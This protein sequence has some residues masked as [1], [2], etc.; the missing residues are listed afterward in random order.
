MTL[1]IIIVIVLVLLS[2]FFSAS[3]TALVSL[4]PAKVRTL[5]ESHKPGSASLA[6]LKQQHHRTLITI[7][8]GNNFVNIAA[9]ALTT[10][11]VT[12]QYGSTAVGIAT[13]VLTLLVLI[14]GEIIP[15][16][17]ATSYSRQFSL[18]FAP[19]LYLLTIILIPI[20][21]T[22]DKFVHALLAFLGSKKQKQVTDEELI[23]MAAIGEEEG[24]ID[25][26]ERAFIENALEFNDI[27]VEEVMTP[28]VH[29]SAM[30]E[31]YNL[32]EAAKFIIHH[33]YS[34]IP[35]YR[36]TIDNIVGIVA[37]KEL[38]KQ[39][40][41]EDEKD[42]TSITLR[43]VDLL[44]PLKISGSMPIHELFHRFKSKKTHM[45]IVLDEHGGTAGLITLEDLLEELVGDIEDEED[46]EDDR[47]KELANGEYELSGRVELDEIKEITG[48]EF[49]Y[50]EYKTLNFLLAEQLGH[51]PKK[52][53][54]IMI[55]DWEFQVIQMWRHTVLKVH[56]KKRTNTD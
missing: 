4:S 16:S 17:L 33:T 7:L 6:R 39:F 14:F 53:Q 36:K 11:M 55:E 13:G 45:A 19:P 2:G 42:L 15:K 44:T 43:Q 1:E 54:K 30:P 9:A 23:A 8:V 5:V 34:R 18:I 24:S 40:H 52:G 37:L 50:P 25:E 12:E 47:I 56:A 29:I 10:V 35:V 22:L 21:W 38:L 20:T 27:R 46:K 28:R 32:D 41:D 31:T 26:H 49:E 51:L 3:E 48:L